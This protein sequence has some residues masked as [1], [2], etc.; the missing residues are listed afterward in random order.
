LNKNLFSIFSMIFV[1]LLLSASARAVSIEVS[2]LTDYRAYDTARINVF[3]EDSAGNPISGGSGNITILLPDNTVLVNKGPISELGGGQYYF[4]SPLPNTEGAYTALVSFSSNAGS[5]SSLFTFHVAGVNWFVELL[6]YSWLA[7]IVISIFFGQKILV[8]QF[9]SKGENFVRILD[10][11][12]NQ[13]KE[14]VI[15][16]ITKKPTREL[17]NN[18]NDFLE[19]FAIEPV[20]LD[21]Y[22]IIKKI[23]HISDLSE[24]RFKYFVKTVSPKSNAESQANIVMGLMGAISLY[25]ITK[26]VRHFVE[27]A[28]KTK[29]I[30]IALM[31]DMNF[32]LLERISKSLLKGTEALA[33]GWPIGDSVG[34][35]VAAKMIGDSKTKE[36]GEDVVAAK[37]K[38]RGKSVIIMKAKGPGGR[39]G[40]L[41]KTA[42]KIIKRNKINKIITIDAAGKLEG[43]KTGTLAEGIGV[44]IGGEGVDRSYIEN[45]AVKQN[46]P[47]DSVVI[48]LAQE[49][50]LEPMPAAVLAAVPRAIKIVENDIAKSHGRILVVGVGNCSGVGNDGKAAQ[51]AEEQAKK[52]LAIMKR[53]ESKQKKGFFDWF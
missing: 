10:G 49:E 33:N 28:K 39:L 29:S 20:N 9:I 50:A 30:Q 1:L 32:P 4:D 48:K 44:A 13:G 6:N 23:E 38:I 43:E 26:V 36:I 19:F 8:Y 37:R 7:F 17:R 16:R 27:L 46:I 41:G 14:F 51:R 53:R 15:K 12:T 11:M 47:I 34:S 40:K 52:V 3:A 2:G 22:G 5:S 45:L 24:K 21:P 25:Q 18:I 42:E 31:M 35:L